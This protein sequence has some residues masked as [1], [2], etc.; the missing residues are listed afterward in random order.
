[1]FGK[2]ESPLGDPTVPA[3]ARLNE[4]YIGEDWKPTREYL[5]EGSRQYTKL[6]ICSRGLQQCSDRTN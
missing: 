3:A 1:M 6:T 2:K 4:I 5:H